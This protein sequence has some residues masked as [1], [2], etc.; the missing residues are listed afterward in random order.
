MT[1]N[2]TSTHN[3]ITVIARQFIEP[4]ARPDVLLSGAGWRREEGTFLMLLPFSPDETL[5]N[6]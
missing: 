1:R 4:G 3:A 5:Y 2:A 6:L